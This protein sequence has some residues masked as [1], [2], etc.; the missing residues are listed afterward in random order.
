ME[1]GSAFRLVMFAGLLLTLAANV[2]GQMSFDSVI[3]LVEAR[4]DTRQTWAPAVSSWVLKPFDHLVAG[5][6]LYVTASA[7]LLF[8]SL[9]SL[10]RLRPRTSWAAVALGVLVVL[11]PQLLIYQGIVWRDVLFANLSLAGFILLAHVAERWDEKPP[12]TLSILGAVACLALASLARQNGLILAVAGAGVL[13]WTARGAGWR[14]SLGWG[15]G[16]FAGMLAIALVWNHVAQPAQT[17]RELKADLGMQILE[18]YDIVGAK[19]HHPT[20]KLKEIAKADPAAADLI[21]RQATTYYDA[22]RVDR[23]DND[24]TFRR[25]LWHVPYPAMDAQWRRVILHYPAA[26]ALQRL[27][28]FRWTF[29]TPK[30]ELCLPVQVGVMGPDNLLHDLDIQSGTSPQA[31]GLGDYAKRFYATPVFSHLTWAVVA[32]GMIVLLLRRREPADW[33]FIGLLGGSLLFAASFAVIS[34]A[35]DYRYLYLLDLAAMVSLLYVA[36][37]PPRWRRV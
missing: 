35:C 36:L 3:S 28:V 21:E 18:H 19:A 12:P 24:P 29:L 6:G 16:A 5:T 37:D 14:K 15:L 7:A 4:T 30:L 20:L 32:A 22:S 25:A 2:P 17:S 8:F 23:L 33:A 13:A 9:M 10:T 1:P 11:T 27:D 34:V 31:K 26:Y